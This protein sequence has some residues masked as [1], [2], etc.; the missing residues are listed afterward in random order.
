[1]TFP[2][3][4]PTVLARIRGP[5]LAYSA[6]PDMIWRETCAEFLYACFNGAPS[7]R[8]AELG[9]EVLAAREN[10]AAA[11]LPGFRRGYR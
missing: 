2:S 11:G 10:A 4:P 6:D 9:N 7:G 5:S 8:L 1:M 3:A